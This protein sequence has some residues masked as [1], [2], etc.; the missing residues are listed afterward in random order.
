MDNEQII[1]FYQLLEKEL[2][3]RTDLSPW[4]SCVFIDENRRGER[5]IEQLLLHGRITAG[6]L[7]F[8]KV[9]LTTDHIHLY[10]KFGFREIGIDRFVWGRPT[11]IYEHHTIKS[12]IFK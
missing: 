3:E 8:D 9:Y 11:K 6:N 2:I 5:L 7:G 4:I 10:E 12:S 1:G